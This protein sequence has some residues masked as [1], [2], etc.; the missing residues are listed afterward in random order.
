[1]RID[2]LISN[3][4]RYNRQTARYLLSSGRV[5][6]NGI[7]VNDACLDVRVFDSVQIDDEVIQAG[8]PARYLMLHKPA[9]YVSATE[10]PQHPTVLDLIGEPGSAL[11][12]AGRLDLNTTGLLLL[13][14]DGQ[15]SRRLTSPSRR[16]AKVYLVETENPIDPKCIDAFAQGLY[17][18]YEGITTLP[19]ELDILEPR[20]ARLTLQEGRYHQVKR[21]F[22]HFRNRVTCLHREAIGPL[23][24]SELAPGMFRSLTAAEIATF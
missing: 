17:F 3:L 5:R 14:N 20:L 10:H 11:H 16:H 13:T 24:V 15:W 9:G 4:P 6:V 18:A 19:A 21:M 7:L 8:L 2:R 23:T 12:L 22:G 1:M